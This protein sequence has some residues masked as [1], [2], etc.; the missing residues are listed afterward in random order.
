MKFNI[1][2]ASLSFLVTLTVFSTANAKLVSATQ[3]EGQIINIVPD[4][5][6]VNVVIKQSGG[7]VKAVYIPRSRY[8]EDL[9]DRAVQAYNTK[10]NF[11]ITTKKTEISL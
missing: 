2:L 10:T 8:N 9:V 3:A 7:L 11:K 6:G 1:I 5:E 4:E